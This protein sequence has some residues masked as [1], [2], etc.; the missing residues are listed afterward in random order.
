MSDIALTFGPLDYAFIALVFGSPGLIA[1][2]VLGALAWRGH[3]VAGA[4]LGAIAGILLWGVGWFY[5][6]EFV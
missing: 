5:L 4:V 3:R 1:G 2:G 6:K